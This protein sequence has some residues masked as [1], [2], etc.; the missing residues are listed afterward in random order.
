MAALQQFDVE[1]ISVGQDDQASNN[2]SAS[3]GT[4]PVNPRRSAILQATPQ[5]RLDEAAVS[6]GEMGEP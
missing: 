3:A 6:A 2:T 5:R 1:A 4:S